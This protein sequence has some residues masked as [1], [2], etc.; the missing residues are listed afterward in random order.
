MK[1][2][3]YGTEVKTA[4]GKIDAIITAANIRGDSVSYEISYFNNGEHKDVWVKECE[5]IPK[6]K[7]K[8]II[9]YK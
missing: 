7:E 6:T 2:L 5:I 1:I 4:I 8:V 3:K 9:G